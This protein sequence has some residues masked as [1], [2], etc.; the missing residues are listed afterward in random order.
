MQ[1]LPV[2]LKDLSITVSLYLQRACE[3]C[4][5]VYRWQVDVGTLDV[6][7]FRLERLA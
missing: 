6:C 4:R 5:P 2:N 3:R 1:L 7:A